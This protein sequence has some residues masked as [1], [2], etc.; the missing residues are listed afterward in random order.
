MNNDELKHYGVLGMKWGVRRYQPY[1]KSGGPKGKFVG[2][3]KRRKK[4]SIKRTTTVKKGTAIG[5]DKK[6]KSVK[7]R[8]TKT[9]KKGTALGI[10]Y[11]SQDKA[12]KRAAKKQARIDSS[13]KE[14]IEYAS[15]MA[16]EKKKGKSVADALLN[17]EKKAKE[18]GKVDKDFLNNKNISKKA[19]DRVI[20]SAEKTAKKQAKEASKKEKK[21]NTS[22]VKKLSDAELQK[23]VQRLRLEEQYHN[24]SDSNVSTG[25]LIAE[26]TLGFIGKNIVLPYVKQEGVAM[27]RS[28]VEEMRK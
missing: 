13:K 24:L 10:E 4:L 21:D 28:A 18:T 15:K 20:S 3:A 16:A 5:I 23:R 2:D 6:T 1:P 12:N 26:E 7:I 11:E 27:V 22:A 8:R 25:R 17:A 19:K 14:G 9:P